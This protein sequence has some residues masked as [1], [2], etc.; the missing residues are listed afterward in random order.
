ML[1]TF[2]N[3]PKGLFKVCKSRNA[4]LTAKNNFNLP[5]AV[6]T[7]VNKNFMERMHPILSNLKNLY[8]EPNGIF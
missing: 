2:K 6:K 8:F 4:L 5:H 1:Y 7:Q 3:L